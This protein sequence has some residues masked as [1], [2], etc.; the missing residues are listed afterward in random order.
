RMVD[1][2]DATGAMLASLAGAAVTSVVRGVV[3]DAY[4]TARYNR[5]INS[6]D[7]GIFD[8]E[9]AAHRN[10]SNYSSILMG[11]LKGDIA[12]P[13]AQP[14]RIVGIDGYLKDGAAV[15]A[16]AVKSKI[17]QV[18]EF[19]EA[20]YSDTTTLS[21]VIQV[22]N[23]A[24]DSQFQAEFE[25]KLKDNGL[26]ESYEDINK[27]GVMTGDETVMANISRVKA[28]TANEFYARTDVKN[29]N[30]NIGELQQMTELVK[31]E[32]AP[33]A[34]AGT[35]FFA[36]D[37]TIRAGTDMIYRVTAQDGKSKMTLTPSK[38]GYEDVKLIQGTTVDPSGY[39][40][41]A[42]RY[43]YHGETAQAYPV[44]RS[45]GLMPTIA[46]SL[47]QSMFEYGWQSLAMGLPM[48]PDGKLGSYG[49]YRY[50]QQLQ[51][52]TGSASQPGNMAN[53][54]AENSASIAQDIIGR[55]VLTT[56][57]NTPAGSL[58]QMSPFIP[59]ANYK[60]QPFSM[61]I[62]MKTSFGSAETRFFSNWPTSMVNVVSGDLL[63]NKF[64]S[65]YLKAT[66]SYSTVDQGTVNGD[67][68]F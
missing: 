31:I 33:A 20:Q 49:W 51:S 46:G 29:L 53:T 14:Y 8:P 63:H 1:G 21:D 68:K 56:I 52:L 57:S 13:D 3:W 67:K 41:K 32:R 47:S 48:T 54:M 55:N 18:M 58:F 45:P 22:G 9:V 23:K 26:Y 24:V 10:V 19:A 4:N 6:I 44:A 15:P 65:G 37:N 60:G 2:K 64:K 16:E 35:Y 28:D 25:Q 42:D 38:A 59:I 40:V 7:K 39:L 50:T 36:P 62:V 12:L 27:R 11:R 30:R 61:A 43:S 66:S 34:V 5:E 17:G